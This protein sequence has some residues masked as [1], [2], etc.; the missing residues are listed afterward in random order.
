MKWTDEGEA[1]EGEAERAEAV[2]TRDVPEEVT[3]GRLLMLFLPS[4]VPASSS[5]PSSC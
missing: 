3:S 2:E 1:E 5:V 4:S